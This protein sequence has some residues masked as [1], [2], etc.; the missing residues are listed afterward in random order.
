MRTRISRIRS[1][2][3]GED[4]YGRPA[5]R[6]RAR[7]HRKFEPP[8]ARRRARGQRGLVPCVRV[9]RGSDR[10]AA[11]KIDTDGRRYVHEL[12]DIE[13][14]NRRA[15]AG[16]LE[17]SAVSFHAYAYLA[18]QIGWPRGRSIRTAGV[19][20]TSSATSKV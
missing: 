11:G 8:R 10:M 20:C 7:R 14:L 16:E 18:D 15:L 6:A 5:L 12:G 13:S 19:T 3:R 1:D 9:S 2:G 4:R 17:V